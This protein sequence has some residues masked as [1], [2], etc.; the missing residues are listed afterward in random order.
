M[1]ASRRRVIAGGLAL[2]ATQAWALEP[3][4]AIGA[5]QKDGLSL[6]PRR[7]VALLHDNVEGVLGHANLLRVLVSESEVD[8]AALYGL[9]FPPV[10]G[11]AR[12]GAVRGLLLE[13]DPAD[14]TAL[15]VTVLAKPD[16]PQA[17][18]TNISLSNSDT[19]WRSL[20]VGISRVAGE[21]VPREGLALQFI[22]PIITDPVQAD[23]KGAAALV[24][25][26]VKVLMA[27]ADALRR[28]DLTAI[29]ALST[30]EAAESIAALPPEILKM[31]RAEAPSMQA[32]LKSVRRVVIRRAT[33]A[34]QLKDGWASLVKVD[35]MW[36]AAD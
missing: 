8:P 19:L 20:E 24:C 34:V 25:E 13:F 31:A 22:A 21:L 10:R 28:G 29:A 26:P 7:A 9:I 5:Y 6:A 2:A 11:L 16:D 4:V 30:P 17:F 33:A 14:R 1:K 15:Q 18:L 27:R 35:G 23:L 32:E 36:K 12:R 3:G